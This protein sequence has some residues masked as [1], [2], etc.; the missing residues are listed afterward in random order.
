MIPKFEKKSF[1]IVCRA[2]RDE[3]IDVMAYIEYV[4][5]DVY[6]ILHFNQ[7]SELAISLNIF[8]FSANNSKT[9]SKFEKKKIH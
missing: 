4:M 3:S 5:I 9:N 2:R 1:P 6:N 8:L 7:Y